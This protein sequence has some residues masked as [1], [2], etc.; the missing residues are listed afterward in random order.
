MADVEK[1]VLV[2]FKYGTPKPLNFRETM[3]TDWLDADLQARTAMN[4]NVYEYD[5]EKYES[6]DSLVAALKN[7][8]YDMID[9]C[10]KKMSEGSVV[11]GETQKRLAREI[12]KELSDLGVTAEADVFSFALTADSESLYKDMRDQIFNGAYVDRTD[13]PCKDYLEKFKPDCVLQGDPGRMNN[14]FLMNTQRYEYCIE[15]G[16]KREENANFCTKCG[17][18]FPV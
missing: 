12:E 5:T 16:T 15:C 2:S 6:K 18:K 4:I 14:P 17:Y 7:C 8:M 13:R 11:R 9:K 10:L 1:T 3:G